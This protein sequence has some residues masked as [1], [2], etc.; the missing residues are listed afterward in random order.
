LKTKSPGTGNWAT[1]P[2]AVSVEECSLVVGRRAG[3][4]GLEM[5]NT[6]IQT[7]I[8]SLLNRIEK[9]CTVFG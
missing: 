7:C 3:N 4:A 2:C 8:H 5:N 9:E 6:Y 1:R